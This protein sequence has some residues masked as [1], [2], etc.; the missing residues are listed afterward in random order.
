MLNLSPQAAAQ[1]RA[2][3]LPFPAPLQVK[4]G[5]HTG[6]SWVWQRFGVLRM[7]RTPGVGSSPYTLQAGNSSPFKCVGSEAGSY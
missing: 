5:R 3:A 2:L 1:S 7:I 4:I 6:V